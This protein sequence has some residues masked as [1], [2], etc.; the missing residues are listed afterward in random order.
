[1]IYEL[2]F[3]HTLKGKALKLEVTVPEEDM[4]RFETEMDHDPNVKYWHR[5]GGNGWCEITT[6]PSMPSI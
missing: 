2:T 1:M 6:K 3:C 4:D 5:F